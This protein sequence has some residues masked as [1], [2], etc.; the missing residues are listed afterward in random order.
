MWCLYG[1]VSGCQ[2]CFRAMN[3]F[4]R[5]TLIRILLGS[6]G[7]A[8]DR[9]SKKDK[10]S[11]E[12]KHVAVN[13]CLMPV[14]AADGCH[15]TTIEGIG[16]VKGD[17][18]HPIQR[19][20]VEM[21]GSQCGFCTPGIIVAIYSLYAGTKKPST[22][23]IEEH[24]DGNLCRC[25]GYRPI[26]DAARSLCDDAEELVRG[27]C[28]TPCRECN[29]REVCEQDC[30]VED[31]Q[32]ADEGKIVI[33]SSKDKMAM[34]EHLT[35]GRPDW[36][37]QPRKMFPAELLDAGSADSLALTKPMMVV[38]STDYHGAG[39]WLKP[40]NLLGLLKLLKEFGDPAGGGYKIVVG[41]TEVGI[42]TFVNGSRMNTPQS[43]RTLDAHGNLFFVY[44]AVFHQ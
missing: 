33:T 32:K 31:K 24:M 39:T 26:W 44:F 27:P 6:F 25:T 7:V 17:N 28:G 15:V 43:I 20:M 4:L 23:Y 42:G 38:D 12:L 19:A 40:T 41:N 36:A 10:E 21:H 8:P 30:N 16:T 3:D 2:S 5:G 14:L 1:H 35:S 11:G 34:K 37:E 13:A 18:L 29:E 22:K 9:I